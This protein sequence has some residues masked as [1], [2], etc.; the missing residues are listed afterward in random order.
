MG[1][2]NDHV[3]PYLIHLSMRNRRVAKHRQRII[4]AAR[5]RVLEIGIGS[6]LNLPFYSGEVTELVGIE[7]SARLAEMARRSAGDTPFDVR[8]EP[9]SAEM[10]P[11]ENQSF[12]SVVST[13]TLCSIPDVRAALAEM[14]RVLKPGGDFIFIEHGA[15]P[16]AGVA[17]WQR[18]VDPVW[19]RFAGGCHVNRPID[20]LIER[21]GFRI[22]RLETG[23]LV[24]GPR[25]LTFHYEGRASRE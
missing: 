1:F 17:A 18:R 14:R 25:V 7:P 3:L 4:P 19:T 15:S 16:D 23:Y 11:F 20:D 21:S 24:E 8:L 2:Y 10:L 22:S 13:W 9:H 12:D 6:G 5:G